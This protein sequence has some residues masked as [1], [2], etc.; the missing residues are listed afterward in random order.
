ML[1]ALTQSAALQWPTIGTKSVAR[2]CIR[3]RHFLVETRSRSVVSQPFHQHQLQALSFSTN[4][5]PVS[6]TI[7]APTESCDIV[8]GP[9]LLRTSVHRPRPSLLYFPGLRSL[10]FWTQDGSDR[11]AYQ[12]PSITAAIGHLHDNFETLLAEYKRVAPQRPSDYVVAADAEHN[13]TL[14]NGS[15]DW[16][17][18]MTKGTVQAGFCEHFPKTA[19]VLQKLRDDKLLFE[20][21]PFGY[22]FYSTLHG[23]SKIAAHSAPMN[24]RVRV[25]LPLLVPSVKDATHCG[26]RVGPTT[27]QWHV[28]QALVLDDSYD[29]QVW[30]ET[31][32][33]RVVLLVDLWH[34]D[35]TMGEREDIVQMFQHAREQGWWS[36]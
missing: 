23:K 34:P 28:G 31:N 13:S 32:E 36:P 5:E 12:E 21:T 11:V 4:R 22:C 9:S 18:Y 3:R 15:W 7:N 19:S 35:V 6:S 8:S 30:N 17:S 16:H 27:R 14:H 29:H 25:H 24:F 26:I 10:P 2:S 20:G 33:T 1:I